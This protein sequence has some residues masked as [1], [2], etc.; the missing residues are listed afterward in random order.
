LR[1]IAGNSAEVGQRVTVR[2]DMRRRLDGIAVAPGVVA[3][4]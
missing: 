4:R 2:I 1:G 3:L